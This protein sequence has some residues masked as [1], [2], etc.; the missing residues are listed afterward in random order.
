MFAVMGVTGQVGG[1]AARALL[2]EKLPVRAILRDASKAQPWKDLGAE[3]FIADATDVDALTK[4]LS[5]IEAAFL[6]IPPNFM[7]APDFP[8]AQAALNAYEQA[9]SAAQPGRV[10]YLSSIGSQLDHGLGLITQTHMLEVQLGK[11]PIAQAFLRPGWF[12]ENSVWDVASAKEGVIN[13]YLQPLDR[14]VPM[15]ST[16]DIG[17]IAADVLK[18]TWTGTRIVEIDGPEGVSPNDLAEA[19]ADVLQR[20]VLPKVVPQE[21]WQPNFLAMGMPADRTAPRIDMLKNFNDGWIRYEG[22][23]AEYRKGT[24]TIREALKAL[25]GRA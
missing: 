16:E 9:V 14:K 4:A 18:E 22:P 12:M 17:R 19:F 10:V 13:S 3:I 6:L 24:V 23:P 1:A 11:L 7:P 8:E 25:V 15:V 20:P 21:E 5:G 2:A